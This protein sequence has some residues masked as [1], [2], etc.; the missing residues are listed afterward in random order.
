MPAATFDPKS[1]PETEE[2]IDFTDIEQAYP[3]PTD[4]GFDSIVVV[5][6][7]PVVDQSKEEKLITVLRKLI[8]KA[9]GPIKENGLFMPTES[10]GDK[11]VTK[12]YCFVDFENVE[13]AHAAIKN[14]DGH[15]MDKSHI[16]AVNQLTDVEK[17]TALNDEYVEPEQEEFVQKEHLRSWLTDSQARDQWVMYRADDVSIFWNRKTETP[18]HEYSRTNWTETYVQ[19]SPLGTYLTTFHRQGIALWG[20][21]SW[22]KIV[23]FVHP[24]VK[25][26]DF[27]PNERYLVTWSNEPINVSRIPEGSVNP[28]TE[29][30]EGNQIVI[31]DTLTGALLR[32]FPVVQT[33]DAPKAISWPMFKW[34]PTEKYFARCVAGQQISIYEA[35]SMGLVGKKSVK[36]DGVA[37]FEWS[38]ANPNSGDEK[39][40]QKEEVLAYWTPEVGNQPARVTIMGVPSK[41]IIRTKNLFNVNECKLQWQSQGHYLAVK[42]D[43]HTKTKKSTFTNL[44]IFRLCQKEIPVETLEIKEAVIAFA[45]EPKG[46]RF[47]IITTSDPNL[48]VSAG[49]NGQAPAILKT[50]VGFYYLD[51]SKAVVAYRPLKIF[52]KKTSNHL[53][54]SPKGRHLVA[55][56]L[57]STTVF[58]LE[59]YDLDLEPAADKK[60]VTKEDVGAN[61]HLIATQEHYGVTDVEWD[62]TGRFVI[63]GSSMWRHT[64]DHGYCLWDF[65]GLLLFRQTI[66]KFKQL[67]WR[68]RPESLLSKEQMKKVRKNLRQYS[69]VF[70]EEDLAVGDAATAKLVATRRK[71]VEQWYTWRKQTEKRVAEE[72]AEVGKEIKAV[73]DEGKLEVVEEWIEEVVEETEEIVE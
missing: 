14:L 11:R 73:S 21:P 41:E 17:Y 71:L 26:I 37:D 70:E 47:A 10:K 40:F 30:D 67:L 36:I 69:K 42:V 45:W 18:E 63:T 65:K 66:D 22:N 64:A 59:F 62:P 15:C 61:V 6:N 49:P 72:R 33:G 8:T 25:L 19:W 5:D 16:L 9:A 51:D 34:A 27:S 50:S 60:D 13:S 39:I 3:L 44:E 29:E 12:G 58:D 4:E 1:F 20:G 56:T 48:G 23:R 24:G 31:W 43:R 7:V 2:D 52:D 46:E 35:P 68:P 28:F 54:W 38:P 57:R 32:S 55:A 53:F